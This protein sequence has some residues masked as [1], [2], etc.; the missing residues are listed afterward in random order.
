MHTIVVSDFFLQTNDAGIVD[1]L[2]MTEVN[3]SGQ[4][5]DAVTSQF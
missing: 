1:R 2:R 3:S 4:K 5:W